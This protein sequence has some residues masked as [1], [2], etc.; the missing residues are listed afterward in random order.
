MSNISDPR[1]SPLYCRNAMRL[2]FSG[3]IEYG[4]IQYVD[5]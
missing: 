1:R 2:F 4:R 3:D 5:V